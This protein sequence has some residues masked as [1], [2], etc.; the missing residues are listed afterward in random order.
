M[1]TKGTILDAAGVPLNGRYNTLS[2]SRAETWSASDLI[3][4]ANEHPPEAVIKGLV[5]KGDILLLHGS[6]ESFKSVFIL[7]LAESVAL[8]TSLLMHWNVPRSWRVGVIE[9]EIHEVM[10]GERLQKM[11]PKGNAPKN[12]CF[13]RESALR[14]WRRLGLPQKFESIQNWIEEEEI[15]VLLIDT[16]NDFF[17]GQDNPSA[18][19]DVGTFFDELRNLRVGARGIVRHDRKKKPDFD[20]QINSNERIRG[21][22]EWKEDPEAIISLER[23]DRRTNQVDFEVGKL[24]YG[25]KPQPF[26]LWFDASTFRLTPLPPVVAVLY[27]KESTRAKIIGDCQRRFDLG[28][29]T[30]DQMIGEQKGFLAETQRGHEKVFGI[31]IDRAQGAHWFSF[32]FR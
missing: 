29:R 19:T 9:T 26:S 10:L 22:A 5:N 13:M 25:S 30:V 6:E 32:A 20:G 3:R 28:E 12:M 8:G 16:A 23:T 14:D 1:R 7:Q 21:S 17:R 4:L 27:E 11:F 24:R 18:E 2:E 31:D 15:E